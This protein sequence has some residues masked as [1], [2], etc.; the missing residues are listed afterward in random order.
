MTSLYSISK[1][2][3]VNL[4]EMLE[5]TDENTPTQAISDT[6]QGM[7][8]ELKEKI[9]SIGAFMLNIDLEIDQID[10]VLKRLSDRKKSMSRKKESLE[11]Y[12]LTH[13]VETGVTSIKSD[14]FEIK[15]GKCAESA[16]ID[17]DMLLPS[18]FIVR[19]VTEAPDKMAIKRAIQSGEDVPGAHLEAGNRL[20][21]K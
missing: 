21:V 16:I 4:Y 14:E 9:K 7:Q 1:D 18:K 15:L 13:M 11:K 19:K 20:I 12:L 3:L 6:I 2:Y 17:D 5:S 10:V 8:G